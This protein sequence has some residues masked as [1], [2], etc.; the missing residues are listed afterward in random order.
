M[1]VVVG[2]LVYRWRKNRLWKTWY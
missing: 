2:F 1:S